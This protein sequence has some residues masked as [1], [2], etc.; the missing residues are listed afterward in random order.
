MVGCKIQVATGSGRWQ[1]PD[2]C[3]TADRCSMHCCLPTSACV[4][5]GIRI[6]SPLPDSAMSMTRSCS[7]ESVHA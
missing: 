5:V 7:F 2:G 6:S 4:P 1:L 3:A